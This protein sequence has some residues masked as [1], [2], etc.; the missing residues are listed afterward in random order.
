MR[1]RLLGHA[2]EG[3]DPIHTVRGRR[4]RAGA[5]EWGASV[6][7]RSDPSGGETYAKN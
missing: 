4:P 3:E 6:L 7:I 1:T 5:T 2:G